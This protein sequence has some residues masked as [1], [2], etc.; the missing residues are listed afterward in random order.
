M[1]S[2]QPPA[3]DDPEERTRSS[4]PGV[5]WTWTTRRLKLFGID[6]THEHRR[7]SL[8]GNPNYASA[9]GPDGRRPWKDFTNCSRTK[10]ITT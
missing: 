7:Q 5:C 9:P 1:I 2:A 3:P 8:T 4:P 10:P 6:I